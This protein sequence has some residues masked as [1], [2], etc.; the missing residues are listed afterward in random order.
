MMAVSKI[1]QERQPQKLRSQGYKG[2]LRGQ[3]GHGGRSGGGLLFLGI[4]ISLWIWAAVILGV[5]LLLT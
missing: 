2:S 1:H 5:W 4:T 3:P